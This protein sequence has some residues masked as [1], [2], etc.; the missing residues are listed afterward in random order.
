MADTVK[1][2]K[3]PKKKKSKDKKKKKKGDAMSAFKASVMAQRKADREEEHKTGPV[4]VDS[5]LESLH[6]RT[7]TETILAQLGTLNER[8][9]NA[10]AQYYKDCRRNDYFDED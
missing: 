5:I 3:E 9:D 6:T 1:K 10:L 2:E 4:D 7:T 8:I